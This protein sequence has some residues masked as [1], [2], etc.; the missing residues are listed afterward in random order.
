MFCYQIFY[1]LNL[2]RSGFD[3]WLLIPW[4]WE[5]WVET[6]ARFSIYSTI[7]EPPNTRLLVCKLLAYQGAP[8]IILKQMGCITWS[9]LAWLLAAR[10]Q[11]GQGF[12]IK[13]L[14]ADVG[15]CSVTGIVYCVA[16]FGRYLVVL[17]I[18][19]YSLLRQT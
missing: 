1:R 17:S 14:R 9:I 12:S 2:D 11:T 13:H 5:Y 18:L 6:L 4:V 7:W 10:L 3:E 19:S 8:A 16:E 15:Y